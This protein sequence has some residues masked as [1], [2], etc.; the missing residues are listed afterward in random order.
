MLN[1]FFEKDTNPDRIKVKS[2]YQDGEQIIV[3]L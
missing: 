3:D 2:K 1:V